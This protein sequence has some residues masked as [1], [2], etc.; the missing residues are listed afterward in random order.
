MSASARISAIVIAR[1]SGVKAI[2]ANGRVIPA[3][4]LRLFGQKARSER[5]AVNKSRYCVSL[6]VSSN[7]GLFLSENDEAENG[8]QPVVN[9]IVK[10]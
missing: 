1:N 4:N 3:R 8:S 7:E 10:A 9:E 2:V 5:I 6:D